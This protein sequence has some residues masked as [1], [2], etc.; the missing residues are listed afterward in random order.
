MTE[1]AIHYTELD[2]RAEMFQAIA[3]H[4][5][6]QQSYYFLEVEAIDISLSID[7]ELKVIDMFLPSTDEYFYPVF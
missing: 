2:N 7:G 6:L 4:F 1:S 3:N 5:E